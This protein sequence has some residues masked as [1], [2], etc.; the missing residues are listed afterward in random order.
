M[1]YKYIVI[2]QFFNFPKHRYHQKNTLQFRSLSIYTEDH[3][4][5]FFWTSCYNIVFKRVKLRKSYNSGE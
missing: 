2:D 3:L 4:Y 5:R 1:S